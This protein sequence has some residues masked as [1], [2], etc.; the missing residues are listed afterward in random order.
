[1][2]EQHT[3]I[4]LEQQQWTI[5]VNEVSPVPH[6]TSF[7]ELWKMYANGVAVTLSIYDEEGQFVVYTDV[8]H[9]MSGSNR[10]ESGR[11][12]TINAALQQLIQACYQWDGTWET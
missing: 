10:T 5:V 9:A 6:Q 1:M 8:G 3:R 4:A 12:S 11:F 2:I 7:I